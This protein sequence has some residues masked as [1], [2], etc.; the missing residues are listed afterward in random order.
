MAQIFN[1]VNRSSNSAATVFTLSG[2]RIKRDLYSRLST[3][4]LYKI[5]KFFYLKEEPT[6]VED[7]YDKVKHHPAKL[8]QCHIVHSVDNRS[9]CFLQDKWTDQQSLF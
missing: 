4:I 1:Y 2:T 3:E 5:P 9:P 7:R 6:S 8:Y